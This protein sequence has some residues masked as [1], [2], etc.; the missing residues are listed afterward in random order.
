MLDLVQTLNPANL[1]NL[2]LPLLWLAAGGVS[3]LLIGVIVFVK[4]EEQT[5]P[6]LADEPEI[7]S[8]VARKKRKRR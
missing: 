6:Q 8:R 7:R 3:I 2:P 5:E 4:P 1:A